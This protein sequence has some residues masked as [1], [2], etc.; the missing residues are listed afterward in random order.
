MSLP[1]KKVMQERLVCY[2]LYMRK[3]VMTQFKYMLWQLIF[4]ILLFLGFVSYANEVE[5]K[6]K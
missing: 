6:E 5:T 1:L 4:V 3:L 2:D